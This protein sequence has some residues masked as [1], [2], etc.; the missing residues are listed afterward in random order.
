[1]TEFFTITLIIVLA[2][3]SPGP[4][5]VIV[6][7]HAM[8]SGRNAAILAALGVSC[9]LIIH[10]SYCLLGLAIIITHSL[11]LFSM[12]KYIGA[13]YLIYIGMTGLFSKQKVSAI[14]PPVHSTSTLLNAFF[15]GLLCNLLNPKAIMFILAFFTLIVGAKTPWMVQI[16]YVFEIALV[17]LVWFSLLTFIIT[18]DRIKKKLHKIQYYITKLMGI[19]LIGFGTSIALLRHSA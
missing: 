8:A 11:L 16:G 10:S 7:K 19:V 3:I 5:F 18:H 2:A 9:S 1:M 13:A 12:I 17:G 14:A 15:Q 4:D 6:V